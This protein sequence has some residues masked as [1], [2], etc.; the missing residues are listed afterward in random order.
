MLDRHLDG[1]GAALWRAANLWQRR[2]REA[3]ARYRL[4][5]V[6]FL[7]LA[8][9]ADLAG[10]GPVTQVALARL[11]GADPMMVSQVVRDLEKMRLVR[12]A[13][14][15]GDLRARALALTGEGRRMFDRVAPAVA[16]VQ[17]EVF[18][19]LAGD[20]E[21]FTGALGLLAGAKPRRRV[22]AGHRE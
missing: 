1:P 8:G 4:T 17:H 20:V 10:S 2:Q 21:A 15:P 22:V 6:Q 7:L 16:E 11:C 18:G 13:S 9:L 5:P 12:R 14:H 3:L 19:V